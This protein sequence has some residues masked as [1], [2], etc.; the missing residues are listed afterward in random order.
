MKERR[1]KIN[2]YFLSKKL[3]MVGVDHCLNPWELDK[4]NGIYF[5]NSQ[6][7]INFIKIHTI[8]GKCTLWT[9]SIWSVIMMFFLLLIRKLLHFK[10]ISH[11]AYDRYYGSSILR[12][13]Y[14][15]V[16]VVIIRHSGLNTTKNLYINQHLLI[17][18]RE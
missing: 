12:M 13:T 11:G 8:S 2:L 5:Q 7:Y 17:S 15:K 10:Y 16:S 1:T 14:F 18:I 3:D 4:L 6:I 9:T